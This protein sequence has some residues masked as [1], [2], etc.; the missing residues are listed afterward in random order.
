MKSDQI[1]SHSLFAPVRIIPYTLHPI[2]P[3]SSCICISQSDSRVPSGYNFLR[4]HQSAPLSASHVCMKLGVAC[5]MSGH[6]CH[7]A[8]DK[9]QSWKLYLATLGGYRSLFC[10]HPHP[11]P[12]PVACWLA[13]PSTS[14]TETSLAHFFKYIS[15][16]SC[17][18]HSALLTFS[19][20]S[21]VLKVFKKSAATV[22]QCRG[23]SHSCSRWFCPRIIDRC[24]FSTIPATHTFFNLLNVLNLGCRILLA[25]YVMENSLCFKLMGGLCLPSRPSQRNLCSHNLHRIGQRKSLAMGANWQSWE[26]LSCAVPL[27]AEII[28]LGG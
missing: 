9:S 18:I 28:S 11:N 6:C 13:F 3:A 26:H 12:L 27:P 23:P 14:P 16:H 7:S 2:L 15:T 5:W 4:C 25:N 19:K 22:S 1:D 24:F 17:R 10:S 21:Q 8:L 20:C